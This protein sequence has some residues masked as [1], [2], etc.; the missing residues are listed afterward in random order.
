MAPRTYSSQ[1]QVP[2]IDNPIQVADILPPVIAD[3]VRMMLT[4]QF[5]F[6]QREN[7]RNTLILIRDE[8]DKALQK[9]AKDFVRRT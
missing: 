2:H 1:K 9:G 3:R 4:P 5:P 7:A 6:N 8:L